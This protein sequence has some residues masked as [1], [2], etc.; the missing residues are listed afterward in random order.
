[1]TESISFKSAAH[2]I[3]Y[4]EAMT[5]IGKIYD[6][7]LDPEYSSALYILTADAS[8]WHKAS[9]YISREGIDI[10][11]MLKEVDFSGGY[12]VLMLWAGN[13]FNGQQHVDPLELLRL[14][15]GN[16]Q[17]ALAALKLRRYS[18]HVDDIK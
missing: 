9:D 12:S 11:A 14:D 6:G 2:K 8:T 7:K 13:L 4:L 1:M 16:F 10:D 17:I 3:R 18:I 15:E 5:Q